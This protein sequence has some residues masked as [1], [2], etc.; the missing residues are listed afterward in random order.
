MRCGKRGREEVPWFVSIFRSCDHKGGGNRSAFYAE[1]KHRIGEG[2]WI[3]E[4]V[5]VQWAFCIPLAYPRSMLLVSFVVK[6]EIKSRNK[7]WAHDEMPVY[8][9]GCF[10]HDTLRIFPR[11][12]ILT[13]ALGNTSSVGFSPWCFLGD[14]SYCQPD[15]AHCPVSRVGSHGAKACEFPATWGDFPVSF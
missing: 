14:G 10:S 9:T 4:K 7:Q 2:R 8:C 15:A 1:S 12:L 13:L 3:E 6:A 5:S 11:G